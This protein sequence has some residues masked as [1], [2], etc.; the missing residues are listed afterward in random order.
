MKN[1]KTDNIFTL[2]GLTRTNLHIFTAGILLIL[3]GYLALAV[4]GK[5]DF[6]SLVAGPLLLLAGYVVVIPLAILY[7]DKTMKSD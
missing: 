3:L 5:E 7:R 4:G 1:K 6:L 2:I